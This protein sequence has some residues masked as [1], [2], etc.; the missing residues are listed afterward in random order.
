MIIYLHRSI[1][2]GLGDALLIG[3][4]GHKGI[5]GVNR[6]IMPHIDED[7]ELPSG[8]L[9]FQ[10]NTFDIQESSKVTG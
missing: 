3:K 5:S 10:I 9:R 4:G 6:E 2:H 1:Q 7:S 8:N